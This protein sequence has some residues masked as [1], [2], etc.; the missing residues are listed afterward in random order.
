M[1]IIQSG[2][3][4]ERL[5]DVRARMEE[6]C[7]RAGRDMREVTLIAVSKTHPAEA[8]LQAYAAGQ[9][10][11]GENRVQELREKVPAVQALLQDTGQGASLSWH[12]I[13]TLQTNKVRY[14]PKLEGLSMIHSV[15]S[16]KLAVEIERQ[17]EAAGCSVDVLLEVNMAHEETKKGLA[18][19]EVRGLLEAIAPL[20]HLRV[21]G[22]MTIAPLTEE[23]ES[24]RVYFRDL[25]GLMRDLNRAALLPAPMTELSM[26]MSG[27]YGVAIEEG[28][29]YVR[30]GT[31]IFGAR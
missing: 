13:G 21:K 29:T 19:E 23:A 5:R 30:V 25:A 6:A 31:A 8:V 4:G 14:L 18:P 27:D 2:E 9:T 26:G 16:E 10:L 3:I 17:Y 24:N 28:A 15:D 12:L 7:G 1:D 11:F 22:L 20:S